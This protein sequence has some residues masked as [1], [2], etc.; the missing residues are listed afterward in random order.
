MCCLLYTLLLVFIT[1]ILSTFPSCFPSLPTLVHVW[2]T[3]QWIHT[4]LEIYQS[5]EHAESKFSTFGR[6][7]GL[8]SAVCHACLLCLGSSPLLACF[9][10]YGLYLVWRCCSWVWS[11][12]PV[13]LPVLAVYIPQCICPSNST[14]ITLCLS[15][16]WM[17]FHTVCAGFP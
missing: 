15:F 16:S 4:D 1:G 14:L 5:E 7:F 9:C 10:V 11:L 17:S 13:L 6:W 8:A 3:H 2:P 12:D